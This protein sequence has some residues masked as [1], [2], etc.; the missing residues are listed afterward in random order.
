MI[1]MNWFSH[2]GSWLADTWLDAI[3]TLSQTAGS[4]SNWP[5]QSHD[6]AAL[7]QDERIE[8]AILTS[9]FHM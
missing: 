3:K 8:I 9:H 5:R 1:V 4:Y 2:I 7:T 6:N